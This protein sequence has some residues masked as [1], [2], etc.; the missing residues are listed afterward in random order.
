MVLKIGHRGAAGYEPENTLISFKKAV[1][2][3]VDM[4]ELDVHLTNDHHLIVMHDETL[5]RTTNGKGKISEKTLAEIK[6]Y[7][8]KKKFQDIPT[9]NEVFDEFSKKT[10]INVEIKGKK[11]AQATAKLVKS[12]G[13]EKEVI[14]SSN[15]VESLKTV[16]EII[17]EV[18]TALIYFA[19]K[20]VIKQIIFGFF[21]LIIFPITKKI[22]L[23][24]AKSAKVELIHLFFPFATKNFITRLHRESYKVNIWTL[25]SRI[26]N[27]R[28]IKHGVDGLFSDYPNII[29]NF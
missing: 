16:K 14:I 13:L 12:K 29:N 6:K 25:N 23:K 28:M 22:I 2:L 19:T 5:D 24:R 18:K 26:L 20:N 21:S 9:L 15:Y 4:I 11:A 27:K 3:G 8:T 7:K 17:P 1:E 10:K